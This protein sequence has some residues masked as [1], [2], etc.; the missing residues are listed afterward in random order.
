ML[1]LY[2]IPAYRE[3]KMNSNFELDFINNH[4]LTL[5]PIIFI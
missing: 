1:Y 2:P 5:T 4:K 3:K